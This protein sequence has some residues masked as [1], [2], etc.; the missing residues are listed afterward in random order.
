M[1]IF[2]VFI[3][4]GLSQ[5]LMN[6]DSKVHGANMM[7]PILGRQ[8]LGWPHVGPMTLAVNSC[9]SSVYSLPGCFPAARTL[10]Q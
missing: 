9:G 4:C 3:C 10:I 8:D 7:E 6:P 2:V 5:Q 1:D